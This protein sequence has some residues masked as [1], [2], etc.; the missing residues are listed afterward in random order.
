[1]F[2]ESAGKK[3]PADN[4]KITR[5][6][7]DSALEAIADEDKRD[8]LY[9]FDNVPQLIELETHPIKFLL[10]EDFDVAKAIKRLALNW[11]CRSKFFGREKAFQ[12]MTILDNGAMSPEDIAAYETGC[13]QLLN[14]GHIPVYFLDGRIINEQSAATRKKL[15]FYQFHVLSEVRILRIFERV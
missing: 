12:P 7:I 10:R 8:L 3:A 14:G 11:K 15:A 9:A 1:M 4:S 2:D 5:D 6:E 13:L